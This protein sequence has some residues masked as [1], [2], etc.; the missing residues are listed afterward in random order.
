M[1]NKLTDPI[2][3]YQA[4]VGCAILGG[5]LAFAYMSF[6]NY[7]VFVRLASPKEKTELFRK[8]LL[9]LLP[10]LVVLVLG[11]NPSTAKI[12]IFAMIPLI[13]GISSL[14]KDTTNSYE[15]NGGKAY[16]N[17][18]IIRT[19]LISIVVWVVAVVGIV[20]AVNKD[21]RKDFG[22][23][24]LSQLVLPNNFDAEK[25]NG[26]IAQYTKNEDEALKINAK[27]TQVAATRLEELETTGVL[28]SENAKIITSLHNLN[29]KPKSKED[30]IQA[31]DT[32]TDFSIKENDALIVYVKDP[33]KTNADALLSVQSE[34]KK[35]Y[36]TAISLTK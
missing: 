8:L 3:N 24:S 34:L 13:V 2:F 6:T 17:S 20:Y 28:W 12:S 1:K 19:I 10:L 35:A 4:L 22:L 30:L 27:N 15:E 33:S 18:K 29:D 7:K 25:Y 11:F 32:Y 21:F 23:S 26:L 5:P 36:E 31:L 16:G 9:S 14:W